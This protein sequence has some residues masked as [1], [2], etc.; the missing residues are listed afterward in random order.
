[1][2]LLGNGNRRRLASL[3]A[4]AALVVAAALPASAP[5]AGLIAAFDS[6]ETGKGFEIGLVNAST[7]AKLTIPAGVNT[8]ADELHPAL[9][10]DGRYLLFERMQLLP[11]LNGDIVP[12]T[13]RTLFMLDRQTG[14]VTTLNTGSG[15]PAG[16][17]FAHRDPRTVVWGASPTSTSCCITKFQAVNSDNTIGGSTGFGLGFT[18]AAA[19]Q[20]LDA[21]HATLDSNPSNLYFSW[22]VSDANTGGLLDARTTIVGLRE[23]VDPRADFG[24]SDTPVSHPTPRRGDHYVAMDRTVSGDADIQTISFPAETALTPAPAPITTAAPE[25]IPAWSP[26][27]LQLAFVRTTDGRRKLP[28]FDL[29]PGLQTIVNPAIDIGADAPSPQT[30]AFQSSWGGLS[31]A[32]SSALDVPVVTCGTSCITSL[33]T[34]LT[35]VPLKPA[36]STTTTGQTI[37]IFVVR[38]TGKRK[39]LGRSVPK[40]KQ[41]GRVPLGKTRKGRNLFRW[42]G[43]VNGKRLKRGTYLLTFRALRRERVVSTSGSVRFTVTKNGQIRR[44]KAPAL[45]RGHV[46]ELA[47]ERHRRR[48]QRCR[49]VR[50]VLV[51]HEREVEDAGVDRGVHSL[52]LPARVDRAQALHAPVQAERADHGAADATVVRLG[53]GGEDQQLVGD[54]GRVAEREPHAIDVA[55]VVPADVLELLGF[56][57]AVVLE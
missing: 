31:L 15:A 37:G 42:D 13:D 36:V 16:A 44:A 43:K 54:R 3:V 25:R 38:V 41:V 40:I 28:I 53:G 17:T 20:L 55:E 6:Y 48:Q 24:S 8:A 50:I 56:E 9:S 7:G 19:G 27:G 49:G 12:P 57:A 2:D 34:S 45:G 14:I 26:G 22:I 29:T 39:L 33:R 10:I 18:P 30:R 46:F 11:K 52:H 35:R 23:G 47:L 1:M 51:A 5:A 21:P 32:E 4:A